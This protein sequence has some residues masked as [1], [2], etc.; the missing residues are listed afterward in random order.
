MKIGATLWLIVRGVALIATGYLT[1]NGMTFVCVVRGYIYGYI[2][3]IHSTPEGSLKVG[4][5]PH[6]PDV[7]YATFFII[8][9]V[10]LVIACAFAWRNRTRLGVVLS[11]IAFSVFAF[12]ALNVLQFAYPVCNPF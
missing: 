8:M 9:L 3:N 4:P 7:V 6:T 2:H 1:A 12:S 5:A 11:I 10:W